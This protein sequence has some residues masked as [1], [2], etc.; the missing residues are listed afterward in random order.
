MNKDRFGQPG[1]D[2]RSFLFYVA[3]GEEVDAVGENTVEAF[4]MQGPDM[5][6]SSEHLSIVKITGPHLPAV[7]PRHRLYNHLDRAAE[8]SVVWVCA[9]PGAGKTTLVASWLA[10]RHIPALWYQIDEG[11]TDPASFF[12][13]MGMALKR[14]VPR[15][16]KA[17]PHF[18]PG[19][20]FGIHTF[21]RRYFEMLFTRLNSP[22]T[23]VLDNYQEASLESPI[24]E[25]LRD[26]V[27]V[28]PPGV[29]V[30]FISRNSPPRNN[31][32]PEGR[33][34]YG[35]HRLGGNQAHPR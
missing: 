1:A 23:I 22:C 12:Y 33:A 20:H 7:F 19:Y 32:S 17:L 30:I 28:A 35:D 29:N 14:A 26:G 6:S 9:P 16:R 18:T 5:K 24:H 11:D 15:L 25:V 34:P 3:Q 31:D 10:E 13:Y 8:R 27:N 4:T 21:T 2:E